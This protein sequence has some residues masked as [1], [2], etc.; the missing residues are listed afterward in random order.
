MRISYSEEEDFPGQF[1]L[2]RANLGRALRGRRG[3]AALRELRD[4][5]LALPDK[6]LIDG[7]IAKDGAVCAV[8]ALMLDKKMKSLGVAR[9]EALKLLEADYVPYGG[10]EKW[11]GYDDADT[12]EEAKA[13]GIPY[14]VAWRLVE[15][16]DEDLYKADP[17]ERYRRVLAWTE[18][19]LAEAAT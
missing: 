11:D 9:E 3:Q 13:Y 5:L 15:L 16:N 17:E 19:Q 12:A 1:S 4:A 18:K 6:K 14:M 8:G 2:W 10:W 7:H